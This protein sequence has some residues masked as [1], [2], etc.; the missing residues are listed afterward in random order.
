MRHA[1]LLLQQQAEFAPD[2]HHQSVCDKIS[3]GWNGFTS[4]VALLGALCGVAC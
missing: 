2:C 4:A 3:K 1:C